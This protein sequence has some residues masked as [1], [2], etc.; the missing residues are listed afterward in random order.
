[1]PFTPGTIASFRRADLIAA[2]ERM[3][4]QA[5][6]R[7]FRSL[8]K[9]QLRDEVLRAARQVPEFAAEVCRM[10]EHMEGGLLRALDRHIAR[11]KEA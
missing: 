6:P 8:S 2:C 11:R 5:Q 10:A 4:Q 7:G 1:M 9:D 3:T